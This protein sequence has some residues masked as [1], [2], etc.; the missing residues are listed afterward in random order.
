MSTKTCVTCKE[1]GITNYERCGECSNHVHGDPDCRHIYWD[2]VICKSCWVKFV[3]AVLKQEK[4]SGAK[5][6]AKKSYF[7]TH[8]CPICVGEKHYCNGC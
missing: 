4:D 2:R 6:H 7:H 5:P 8:H 1:Y 3:A